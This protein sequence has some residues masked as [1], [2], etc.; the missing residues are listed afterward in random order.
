MTGSFCLHMD[1]ATV[2][3]AVEQTWEQR[4]TEIPKGQKYQSG[5]G[6]LTA[7]LLSVN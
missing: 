5:G 7:L 1:T 2:S 4:G 6:H 3:V